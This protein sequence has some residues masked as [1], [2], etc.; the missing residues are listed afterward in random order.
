MDYG[1]T[2]IR[3]GGGAK[4]SREN[5]RGQKSKRKGYQVC[6]NLLFLC[7][8]H[9]LLSNVNP[10][11]IIFVGKAGGQM[12]P[13]FLSV[14]LPLWVEDPIGCMGR[15]KCWWQIYEH[16]C[17]NVDHIQYTKHWGWNVCQ[18]QSLIQSEFAPCYNHLGRD[19]NCTNV[20]LLDGNW[21]LLGKDT[22]ALWQTW[23][24]YCL[25]GSYATQNI[26]IYMQ[27]NKCILMIRTVDL[28]IFFK[29]PFSLALQKSSFMPSCKT[30]QSKANKICKVKVRMSFC[31]MQS[32]IQSG[33]SVCYDWIGLSCNYTNVGLLDKLL[34]LGREMLALWWQT[35]C[36]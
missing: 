2:S 30:P 33:F 16:K 6:K 20:I 15:S 29:I 8:N 31:Q 22:L 27:F 17:Q 9:Q 10:F 11:F 21:K 4:E 12:P 35:W 18:I 19:A 3:I 26:H 5:L 24:Q 13:S 28:C 1:G 25:L 32:V 34:S 23:Y 14:V 36:Y 7:W